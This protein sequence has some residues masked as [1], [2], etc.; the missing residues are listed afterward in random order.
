MED[1]GDTHVAPEGSIQTCIPTHMIMEKEPA[2]VAVCLDG[3]GHLDQSLGEL[4][5]PTI[6][7]DPEPGDA[8]ML[9]AGGNPGV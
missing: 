4:S 6:T 7:V 5:K 2:Q 1:A 9:Q 8:R 3:W